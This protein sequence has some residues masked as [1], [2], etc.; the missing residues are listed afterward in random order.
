LYPGYAA[1]LLAVPSWFLCSGAFVLAETGLVS[2]RSVS[3]HRICAEALAKRFPEITVNT[4]QHII[5]DGDIITAGVFLARVDVGLLLV[6]RI[7][8][9]AVR[10]VRP[11]WGHRRELCSRWWA[12][13]RD[14]WP[15]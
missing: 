15:V 2:G 11:L 6:E 7:L 3:T 9:G 14:R 5:E 10:A 8:D 4:N 13:M 12:E 1:I